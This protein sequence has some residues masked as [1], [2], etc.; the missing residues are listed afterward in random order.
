[1]AIKICVPRSWK[2]RVKSSMLHATSLARYCM[3]SIQ[4][5]SATSRIP[6]VR[7]QQRIDQLQHDNSLQREEMR[8]K[9]ARM[10]RLSPHRR[11][12]Y[13][14]IERMAILELRAAR[15]WTA[16]QTAQRFQI[17]E[18]TITNWMRRL[19]EEGPHALVRTRD[20][21]NKFPEPD[22]AFVLTDGVFRSAVGDELE[23][24]V[25]PRYLDVH[26]LPSCERHE[27]TLSESWSN[28]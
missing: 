7:L 20:P 24:E 4:G 1:M 2:R 18:T 12:Y 26:G 10:L 28:C 9:D 14:S 27:C 11:P 23:T 22:A 3:A 17:T 16:A 21:V 6:G 5:K 15:G 19:D 25:L 13:A 8:I